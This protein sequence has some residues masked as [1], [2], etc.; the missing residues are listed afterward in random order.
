MMIILAEIKKLW[1]NLN[2]LLYLLILLIVNVFLIWFL[3]QP[4]NDNVKLSAYKQINQDMSF[5]DM[6]EKNEYLSQKVKYMNAMK[7]MQELQN[8]AND[9]GTDNDHYE[10]LAKENQEIISEYSLEYIKGV[11]LE[12]SNSI[13]SEH[14]FLSE[15]NVEFNKVYNYDGFLEDIRS[16]A[17]IISQISIFQTES[18]FN[19][20]NI[21]KTVEAYENLNNIVI[22]YEPQKGITTALNF[23]PTDAIL[24]F[25]MLLISI[26]LIQREKETGVIN[27]IKST[28]GGHGKT[29]LA[30]IISLFVS[31]FVI[32][33]L[34]Y[35]SNL[36]YCNLVFGL[37][38]L[39]KSVQSI[40]DFMHSVLNI[41]VMQYILMFLLLKYL[42]AIIFGVWVMTAMLF[43]KKLVTGIII[44]LLMPAFLYMI[45]LQISPASSLNV[46]HYAN[47]ISY[48]QTNN[49]LARY[50]NL[51]WFNNPVNLVI[52]IGI[53]A[54]FFLLLFL[55]FY[56]VGFKL[57]RFTQVSSALN[58]IPRQQ[59]SKL[60]TVLKTEGR[61]LLLI[62]TGVLI[63]I[64]ALVYQ[65][66]RVYNTQFY[67]PFEETVYREY[68]QKLDGPFTQGKA[69]LL[70]A[71]EERFMTLIKADDDYRRKRITIEEY[72]NIMNENY[73]LQ[74]E[75]TAY[76]RVIDKLRNID[77]SSGAQLIYETSYQYLFGLA[78][79]TNE[80]LHMSI[81]S[82][83]LIILAL[84]GLF[85]MERLSGMRRILYSTPLGREAT[86]KSKLFLSAIYC[87]FIALITS[88]PILINTIRFYGL[89]GVFAPIK[90]L[91]E[92]SNLP[93]YILI[94]FV[95]IASFIMRLAAC[96]FVGAVTLYISQKHSSKIVVIL[97]S[98]SIFLL[99]LILILMGVN[100]FE[101]FSI[102]QFYNFTVT[103]TH[104]YIVFI[105]II[106][107][108]LMLYATYLL[109]CHMIN[110]YCWYFTD[111]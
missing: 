92:Y 58:Y 57:G 93:S 2:F 39:S 102:Y 103:L 13:I 20:K 85:S 88:L 56:F 5:M 30:K 84:S 34:I 99:P 101:F 50:Q 24:V 52:V 106:S 17:N 71:E 43:A 86:V 21:A 72:H 32:V 74:I 16:K 110:K 25:V 77:P 41:N 10:H 51:Y 19:E 55:T 53:S 104:R 111:L 54:L 45:T 107:L 98:L 31:L 14:A 76:K 87:F 83:V 82:V 81:L 48:L 61:K 38:D 67:L 12:Y 49:I 9:H 7:T 91:E 37:G 89:S 63:I 95:I 96:A 11:T 73:H 60:T 15:I 90:S 29:A 27:L 28:A 66:Y 4:T 18:G 8:F 94:F 69:E 105:P 68:I 70:Q 79:F 6:D 80:N 100:V 23:A 22:E 40:P 35:A 59:K 46:V 3:T 108:L 78:N 47:P 44:S 62:N 75:Y 64:F 109:S 97:I 42:S 33:N 1:G 26:V 36:I 65:G